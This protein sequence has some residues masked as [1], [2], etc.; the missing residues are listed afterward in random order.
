MNDTLPNGWKWS[1]LIDVATLQ[2]GYD[3]PV[4][5]RVSGDIPVFAA[6]GPIG[7]HNEAKVKGPGVVTGRSG[8]IGKVHFAES[9]F[10]PLNTS[11]FV[12]DFHRNNPRFVFYLLKSLHLERY[13]EGT[14]VPTLNRNNVHGVKVPL[15]PLP[16]QKRI[17]SILDKVDAL[18]LKREQAITKLDDLLQSVFL[19]MFGDPVTNPKGW[20]ESLLGDV[21][22]SAKDGPHV[23][24]KYSDSGIPFLSTRN[25]KRGKVV[26]KDLKY[27]DSDE[28]DRQWK[29]CKPER[30]DI[31]YTKGGT[32]G[33]AVCKD[34][35]EPIAIWVHIALLKTNFNL[36][37][38]FW[39]ECMLNTSYCYTQSQRY[40]H[41]IA[42]KDLGLTRMIKIKMYKPPLKLQKQF[43][44][45]YKKVK[46]LTTSKSTSLSVLNSLFES[47]QK[48][49]F[50]GEL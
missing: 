41:G 31:L 24:P 22:H 3:L 30:G 16:E 39:L 50:K 4:K 9:D 12:K 44:K 34:F 14:G 43:T 11:L 45:L 2:R 21:I 18:R 13:H 1:P 6:N 29:K 40:T 23:S 38:P 47:V 35:E 17:A 5:K 42:N 46:Q 27:I 49:A 19:D 20:D 25:I 28:A 33:I 26:W 37:S 15:P 36:V 10:W 48:Q 32:T 8:S 7:T